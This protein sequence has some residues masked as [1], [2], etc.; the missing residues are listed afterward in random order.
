LKD[1]EDSWLVGDNVVADIISIM[2]DIMIHTAVVLIIPRCCDSRREA[3][4]NVYN[5]KSSTW[6]KNII[7][8]YRQLADSVFYKIPMDNS[9]SPSSQRFD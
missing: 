8:K 6:R 5:R 3:K 1:W 9:Q 7:L 2:T 4:R